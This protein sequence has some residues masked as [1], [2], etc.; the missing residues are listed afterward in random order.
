VLLVLI[1]HAV[2][3]IGPMLLL[4]V[5]DGRPGAWGV[6]GVLALLSLA[7]LR[8]EL[9]RQRRP[10]AL[11]AVVSATWLLGVALAALGHRYA[12]L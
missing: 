12:L 9:R 7:C 4:A 6:L 11:S 5:R 2:A 1:G 8:F 10:G 3:L